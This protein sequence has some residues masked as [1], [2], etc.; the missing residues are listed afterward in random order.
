MKK[1][2][3]EYMKKPENREQ[4][5]KEAANIFKIVSEEMQTRKQSEDSKK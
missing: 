2:V 4:I 5:Y 3:V 1:Q